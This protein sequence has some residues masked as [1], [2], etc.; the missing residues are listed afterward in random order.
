MAIDSEQLKKYA[1]RLI[2][3]LGDDVSHLAGSGEPLRAVQRVALRLEPYKPVQERTKH[4]QSSPESRHREEGQVVEE[5]RILTEWATRESDT[6]HP[7]LILAPFGSGK[8]VLLAAFAVKLAEQLLLD[9]PKDEPEHFLVPWPVRLR[10]IIEYENDHGGA[11]DFLKFLH[12]SQCIVAPDIDEGAIEWAVFEQL[13]RAQRLVLLF[14]G[15]DELPGEY[16]STS[17]VSRASV[18]RAI[19][20]TCGQYFAIA[21]RPGYEVELEVEPHHQYVVRELTHEEVEQYLNGQFDGDPRRLETVRDA[22]RNSSRLTNLL[23]RPLFL[24]AWRRL[25]PR[26]GSRPPETLAAIMT[27]LTLRCFDDRQGVRITRSQSPAIFSAVGALLEVFARHGFDNNLNVDAL[28]AELA[29]HSELCRIDRFREALNQAVAAGLLVR[30]AE[31]SWYAIKIPPV[32]FLVGHGLAE[33]ALAH[34]TGPLMLIDRFRRWIWTPTLYDTLDYTFDALWQGTNRQR[35]WAR[36]LL[37]WAVAVRFHD[38]IQ[39]T[40][41]TPLAN[42]DLCRPFV[43]AALRWLTLNAVPD[44]LDSAVEDDALKEVPSVLS[45]D[46]RLVDDISELLDSIR[47]RDACFASLILALAEKRQV[48]LN[49][50]MN[51]S[52]DKGMWDLI[53]KNSS[54]AALATIEMLLGHD[55]FVDQLAICDWPRALIASA[56]DRITAQE[57]LQLLARGLRGFEQS[58]TLGEQHGW[59]YVVR[60]AARDIQGGAAA[61]VNRWIEQYRNSG[62]DHWWSAILGGIESLAERD[63]PQVIENLI[64]CYISSS[65]RSNS[66]PDGGEMDQK[67]AWNFLILLAVPRVGESESVDLVDRFVEAFGGPHADQD[68]IQLLIGAVE[69]ACTKVGRRTLGG[70]I[71]GWLKRHD[72][73]RIPSVKEAWRMAI[74]TATTRMHKEDAS[75]AIKWINE[76]VACNGDHDAKNNRWIAIEAIVCQVDRVDCDAIIECLLAQLDACD[77]PADRKC[78]LSTITEAAWH[79]SDRSV[80]RWSTFFFDR[81]TRAYTSDEQ[82]EWRSAFEHVAANLHPVGLINLI[83]SLASSHKRLGQSGHQFALARTLA[84]AGEGVNPQDL[85]EPLVDD[86]LSA[87]NKGDRDLAV[88]VL[89][90]SHLLD[91]YPHAVQLMRKLDVFRETSNSELLGVVARAISSQDAILLVGEF[92]EQ[93]YDFYDSQ[94]G[95]EISS[96]LISTLATRVDNSDAAIAIRTWAM[97]FEATSGPAK[98]A[99]GVAIEF[100]CFSPLGIA[101]ESICNELIRIGLTDAAFSIARRHSFLAIVTDLP[102]GSMN[103]KVVDMTGRTITPLRIVRR[104][105]LMLDASLAAAPACVHSA[106]FSEVKRKIE[107]LEEAVPARAGPSGD[108]RQTVEERRGEIHALLEELQ[109]FASFKNFRNSTRELT[110]RLRAMQRAD[111]S[112]QPIASLDPTSADVAQTELMA[113][114]RQFTELL[115]AACRPDVDRDNV[116]I[117]IAYQRLESMLLSGLPQR[118]NAIGVRS[119]ALAC[120]FRFVV[121]PSD[122]GDSDKSTGARTTYALLSQANL[123]AFAMKAGI[124]RELSRD[125]SKAA[126]DAL[127]A[128][129]RGFSAIQYFASGSKGE[130]TT[131]SQLAKTRQAFGTRLRDA[132]RTLTARFGPGIETALQESGIFEP[133]R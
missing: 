78:W 81:L 43:L 109:Q 13:Y 44:A 106:L 80:I 76:V 33:D 29:G 79:V 67:R 55:W 71:D 96:E 97:R 111:K 99:W 22:I 50:D 132:R 17:R 18:L 6:R 28:A 100:L 70:T 8:S 83:N 25:V 82:D 2:A 39:G 101:A 123:R 68:T 108:D 48:V 113:V 40:P 31:N 51:V 69:M 16:D 64:A 85:V 54:N 122:D 38:G 119:A 115:K 37:Q 84:S 89:V 88:F 133:T 5:M 94:E 102:V 124:E 86:Y 12:H 7:L 34:P 19:K 32:E 92:I 65:G 130:P 9:L 15:F 14:D 105:R 53:H 107:S 93:Y 4:F 116:D 114:R 56:T 57:S 58:K 36:S 87:T 23:R 90:Y 26:D 73:S 77:D 117:L 45:I 42:D 24:T 98:T 59:C 110:Q 11:H 46:V 49:D 35:F 41:I 112:P 125:G 91:D 21:S 131:K 118:P 104:D 60:A 61:H 52:W 3:R 63:V 127:E 62:E 27:E 95:R 30:A 74:Q 47:L 1:T 75:Y 10:S 120:L 126:N 128:W 66:G 121:L 129:R 103:A 72:E 20:A